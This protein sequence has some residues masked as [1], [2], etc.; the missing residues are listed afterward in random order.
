MHRGRSERHFRHRRCGF[1]G[2]GAERRQSILFGFGIA[3]E[4]AAGSGFLMRSAFH[5]NVT[6]DQIVNGPGRVEATGTR[7]KQITAAVPLM[8]GA[9]LRG[10]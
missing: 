5:E 6:E 9:V 7:K 8:I 1:R 10:R 2:C 4:V 3:D